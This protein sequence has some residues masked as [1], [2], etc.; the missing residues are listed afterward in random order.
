MSI[1][2][3]HAVYGEK[4][5]VITKLAPTRYDKVGEGFGCYAE[6]VDTVE[7]ITPAVK[8]AFASGKPAVIN[9][10]TSAKVVH[11]VTNSLLGDLD[12]TDEIVV[13]YYKNIPKG[14][15]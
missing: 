9:I 2:G 15:V 13:P 6:H 7:E 3:Q 14:A 8:R 11:P 12:A 1:H 5:D 4:G 10:V